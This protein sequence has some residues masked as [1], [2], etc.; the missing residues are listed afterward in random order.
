MLPQ[1][2]LGPGSGS[3]SCPSKR[4]LMRAR[5]YDLTDA[6]VLL[7]TARPVCCV[8]GTSVCDRIPRTSRRLHRASA[9][10]TPS[11]VRSRL[12]RTAI[13]SVALAA[14]MLSIV[15]GVILRK[16]LSRSYRR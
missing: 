8:Y 4:L 13:V 11:F 16:K 5:S 7:S 3:R 2:L 1:Y 6:I 10:S 15:L 14:L 12:S 9:M